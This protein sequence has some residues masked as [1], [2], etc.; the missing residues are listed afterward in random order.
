MLTVDTWNEPNFW[1]IRHWLLRATFS[2]GGATIHRFTFTMLA[3]CPLVPRRSTSQ[4]ETPTRLFA[5]L[6]ADDVLPSVCWWIKA[7][8]ATFVSCGPVSTK[9]VYQPCRWH[10]LPRAI[11]IANGCQS[12]LSTDH[13]SS[14][15]FFFLFFRSETFTFSCNEVIRLMLCPDREASRFNFLLMIST[16]SMPAPKL[17]C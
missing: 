11:V 14:F 1:I 16:T 10:L 9:I 12:N 4:T 2:L 3:W 7:P 17:E 8:M 5:V 6:R 15:L 13:S